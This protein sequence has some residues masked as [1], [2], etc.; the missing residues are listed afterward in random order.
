MAIEVPNSA[1]E[2]DQRMKVDVTRELPNSNPFLKNSWLGA[3]VTA[4]A[5]RVFDFYFALKRA[6]L[7]SIPDTAVLRLEQWA[8]I[9]AITRIAATVASGRIAL[10]GTIGGTV[11]DDV[12]IWTSTDGKQYIA[13]EGGV[14][15]LQSLSVDT[16]TETGGIAT[17]TTDNEHLLSSNVLISVSGATQSEYNLT[18][19][20]CTV[21]GAMTLT[22]AVTGSPADATGT[23]L[24]GFTSVS[25]P[26]ASVE[27]GVSENQLADAVITLQSPVT[28]VDDDAGVDF[29][30]LGGGT[31]QEID[32]SIRARLIDKIQNPISHFSVSDITVAAKEIAGVTRVFVEEVEPAVGDVT[33]YFMRDNDITIIPDS[34]EVAIVKAA[35]DAIK[36][37]NS[38]T[39]DVIVLA[40]VP[41]STDY[42]FSAILPNTSTMKTAIENSLIQFYAERT[43][44]GIDIV[45]EAYN[46]AIF[47]TVDLVTGEELISF[48]LDTPSADITIDPSPDAEIGTLGNVTF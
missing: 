6:Q 23:P 20:V 15:A 37:A 13:T 35:I 46:A 24:L 44:V 31:D 29:G 19:V 39:N 3:L 25:I 42:T 16:I 2:I 34:S 33:I 8:S 38:H 1:T 26:V 45:E 32:S 28:D 22:Y 30:A 48:T 18:D 27:F 43:E 41:E 12:T 10:T 14:I 4:L 36:P 47:N 11:V 17:L 40:P 5:N 9:F 7:E 21:T